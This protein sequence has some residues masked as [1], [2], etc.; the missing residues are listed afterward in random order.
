MRRGFGYIAASAVL[1]AVVS[2]LVVAQAATDIT[3]P[4]TIV[5]ISHA[6]KGANVNVGNKADGPGDSFLFV[7]KLFDETDQTQLGDDHGQ[8]TLQPRGWTICS[9]AL[10]ISGRGQIIGQGAITFTP[11][12]TSF[13]FPLTGGTGDFANVRGSAHVESLDPQGNREKITLNL[14]P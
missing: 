1:L 4:E 12:T 7:D 6:G 14:L 2:G 9:V 5:L 3:S 10:F 11:G 13:D 8:C